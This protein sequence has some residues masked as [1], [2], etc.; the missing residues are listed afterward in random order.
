VTK[1]RI[2]HI[3]LGSFGR[4][5]I[6]YLLRSNLFELAGGV[7][8][9]ADARIYAKSQFAIETYATFE[10]AER[11]THFDAVLVATPPQ[12]HFA[13]AA[14]ALES[15]KH[16]LVEKPLSNDL[17]EARR[18]VALAAQYERILVVNQQYRHE[19]A[20]RRMA[21]IIRS[22]RIGKLLN[23]RCRFDRNVQ[24]LLSQTDFRI[25]M[26]HGLIL[27][28]GIHHIDL[29]RALTGEEVIRVYAEGWRMPKSIFAH[30]GAM[31]ALLTLKSGAVALYQGNWASN[32][33]A[34]SW[35]GRWDIEG[36]DGHL[37]W[38]PP[39]DETE[40]S[41]IMLRFPDG[42]QKEVPP[43][44]EPGAEGLNGTLK[45][46][47]QAI[48]SGQRPETSGADNLKTLAV[49]AACIQSMDQHVQIAPQI[50]C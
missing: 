32:D 26:Q 1:T 23:V 16:V 41:K 13:V 30:H 25:G 11:D 15:G 8:L 49:V 10:N 4:K 7:D 37:A 21:A 20:V 29:L 35:W 5:W 34:T 31:T 14:A 22:G 27:D 3:G 46:F 9:S 48:S 28:M 33:L 36:T 24:H 45:S 42:E 50:S 12:T 17:G 39:I 19:P 44:P 18:L 38:Y 6:E 43:A 2:L 40:P 47:V